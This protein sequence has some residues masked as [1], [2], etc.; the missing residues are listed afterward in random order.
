MNKFISDILKEDE[1]WSLKR[2]LAAVF[3]I[4]V[5]THATK[6]IL[7]GPI[8]EG[9]ELLF[10]E[11]LSFITLLLGLTVANKHKAFKSSNLDESG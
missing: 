1:T 9:H 2:I 7:N 6:M 3:S 11:M 5:I 8:E 10:G 4:I